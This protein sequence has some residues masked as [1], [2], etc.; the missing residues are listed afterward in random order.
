MVIALCIVLF[1]GKW[2]QIRRQ[3]KRNQTA[4]ATVIISVATVEAAQS[5][6]TGTVQSDIGNTGDSGAKS[7]FLTKGRS[8][9][10]GKGT[11]FS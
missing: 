9:T 1:S 3:V 4:V 7:G 11:T 10:R 5:E 8:N 2:K 6:V